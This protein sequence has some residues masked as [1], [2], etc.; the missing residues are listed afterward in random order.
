LTRDEETTT[1]DGTLTVFDEDWS[2]ISSTDFSDRIALPPGQD[3][4][5]SVA[6]RRQVIRVPAGRHHFALR[7]SESVSGR[8]GIVRQPVRVPNFATG[9]LALSDIRLSSAVQSEGPKTFE[10]RGRHLMPNPAGVFAVSRPVI[11]YFEVYN[12]EKSPAGRTSATIE[13]SVFPLTGET[14]PV[15]SGTGDAV[16]FPTDETQSALFQEEDGTDTDLFRDIAIEL[17]GAEPGR[18]ALRVTVRDLHAGQTIDTSVVVRLVE[19]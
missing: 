11:L 12:L 18:Y 6:F 13:Y 19:P 17:S 2:Q 8:S 4:R 7:A 16:S 15:L 5:H 10:R 3:N 1:V 9:E 14:R